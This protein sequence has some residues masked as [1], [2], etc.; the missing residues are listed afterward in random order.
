MKDLKKQKYEPP[1]FEVIV[2]ENEGV[3]ASSLPGVND[4]GEMFPTTRSY[5]ATRHSYGTSTSDLEDLI[6]DILTFEQ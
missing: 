1:G 3:I 4:G 2:I 5:R 6:N